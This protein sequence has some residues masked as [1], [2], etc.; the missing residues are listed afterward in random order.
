MAAGRGARGAGSWQLHPL[1]R[2]GGEHEKLVPGGA[3]VQG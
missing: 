3:Y 1:L 2:R